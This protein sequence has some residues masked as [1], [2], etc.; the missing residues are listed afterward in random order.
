M[1]DAEIG[2][3]AVRRICAEYDIRTVMVFGGEP[4]LC[5]EAVRLI[6]SAAR[7][8]NVPR[9]QIITNG[10]FSNVDGEI[11]SM[12]RMLLDSGIKKGMSA[13]LAITTPAGSSVIWQPSGP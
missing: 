13:I 6:M 3:D 9:R 4:L 11:E 10:Y 12:A 5:P 7:E 2:A 8:M 1:L